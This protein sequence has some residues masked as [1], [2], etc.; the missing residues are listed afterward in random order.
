MAR[1]SRTTLETGSRAL[2]G[3]LE[4]H[5]VEVVFGIPGQHALGLW[6]ALA[7]SS[8]RCV[9]VRHEQ[10]AAFAAQGYARTSDRVGVCITSTGPGAF[11]TFA[12]MGEADASS[13]RVLHITTQIP[14]DPGE[15][16]WMHE[17]SGQSAAFAAVT[18]HHARPRS[19]GALAAA[20]DE[21]LTA[22]ALR[23]GPAMVEAYTDVLAAPA[24]GAELRVTPVS[25]PAPD[26]AAVARVGELLSG[27]RAPMIFA[28]GG[29]RAAAARIVDLAEALDAPV[30]TSFN[31]KGVMPAGHPLHAGS[32]CEEPA[33]QALIENADVCL[34]LGTRFAEEY[35][36]HWAVPFPASLVQVDLDAA[37]LGANYA[38]AEGIVADVGLFCDALLGTS[39]SAGTRDGAADARA[40]LSGRSA[41]VTA[42]GFSEEPALL[43]AIADG[44]SERAIVVSDMT[45]LG[46]WAVLYLDATHP[47]GFVYPMSGALGSA[48]PSAL[49]VVAANP[50]SPALAIVGDGGFLM[51]GHELV[52][53]QQ[54]GLH[55]ATLLVNDRC[56]GVLKNYQMNST[57]RTV[58][59]DLE[60]PDFGKLADGYGVGYQRIETA[61]ELP[62]ALAWALAELPRRCAV[63][64][65]AAELKAPGQSV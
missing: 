37:R 28:G 22:I 48:M 36:C 50:D 52:T 33:V 21:A 23:P 61:A 39:P 42:Q 34:A 63:V 32:S 5:G 4:A 56:Y 58:G 62:E 25:L 18:R 30:V 60:S 57:G 10:A 19:P 1:A 54:N 17:T 29:S 26:P 35:T 64:E 16:G 7:D 51:G 40:A 6:D 47:G 41:E 53:A 9:V 55:F 15:R 59:V 8:I 11:N 12:G 43:T 24:E 49:G 38:V 14:S 65:L 13:L 46:Y 20:V 3:A 2:V 31:G 44:L 45:I 27:A